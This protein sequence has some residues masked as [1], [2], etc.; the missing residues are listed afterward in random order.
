MLKSNE[1]FKVKR[2]DIEQIGKKE[3]SPVGFV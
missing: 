2:G 3:E 1:I